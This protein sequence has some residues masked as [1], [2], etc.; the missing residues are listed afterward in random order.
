MTTHLGIRRAA[1]V[2]HTLQES[3]RDWL[4]TQFDADEKRLLLEL[5]SELNSLGIPADK[6][7]LE[8][9][10]AD[11]S[12]RSS[13]FD[14]GKEPFSAIDADTLE[15][16]EERRKRDV[17]DDVHPGKM[18]HMLKDEP[19]ELVAR[20]MAFHTWSWRETTLELLGPLKRS[21]LQR[22]AYMRTSYAPRL[23]GALL[24]I[25][26]SRLAGLEDEHSSS[27][28]A[29]SP[30]R[31]RDVGQRWQDKLRRPFRTRWKS[32]IS[33]QAGQ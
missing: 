29:A 17:L 5:L 21:Q 22:L 15:G 6:A 30:E 20:F 16:A 1:L 2:L 24:D 3:D 4:L 27:H 25:F 26:L 7:L 18:A 12:Q 28:I 19:I 8:Q 14:S 11:V 9:T 23:N 13:T 33:A 32:A 10:I 31:V